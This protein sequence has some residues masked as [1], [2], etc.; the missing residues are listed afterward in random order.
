MAGLGAAISSFMEGLLLGQNTI[1][2]SRAESGIYLAELVVL[3]F[4]PQS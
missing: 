4:A 3:C 1:V 2:S